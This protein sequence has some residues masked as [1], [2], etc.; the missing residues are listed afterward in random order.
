MAIIEKGMYIIDLPMAR[1]ERTTTDSPHEPPSFF[2]AQVV[3]AQRFYLDLN[4]SRRAT[5]VVVCGGWERCRA[6][7]GIH[8]EDFPYY[9]IEF[10]SA[11]KG[12]LRLGDCLADLAA[13]RVFSY[14]PG[15]AQQITTDDADPLVK[16]FVDFVGTRSTHLL[17][18]ARLEPGT[19]ATVASVQA[20]AEIF[21]RLVEEGLGEGR[22]SSELCR[23]LTEY[24]L[25]KLAEESIEHAPAAT[26]AFGTYQRAHRFIRENYRWLKNLGQIAS[27][28]HVDPAYLCRLFRRY[29]RQSPY[30]YLMRLKMG[31]AARQLQDPNTLVKQLAFE[32]GF[33]D[34][35]HFSRAFKKVFGLSPQDF[36]R[37]R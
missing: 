25:L 14:G 33:A 24:L 29:D 35:F 15:I 6:G 16:Y 19:V 10:V 2:S 31:L 8:R 3:E 34:P 37:L 13:G 11:G 20:I 28:C 22:F 9:S 36:R 27:A 23:T 7:Y 21:D 30:Q 1:N 18:Q 17:A 4:P 5:L 32:L 12:S 26:A